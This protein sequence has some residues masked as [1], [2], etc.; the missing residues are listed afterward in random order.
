MGHRSDQVQALLQELEHLLQEQ[1]DKEAFIR[2]QLTANK[3]ATLRLIIILLLEVV[4]E[5]QVINRIYYRDREVMEVQVV[6]VLDM[7]L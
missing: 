4:M 1:T 5:V 7:T 6:V 3:A 2:I